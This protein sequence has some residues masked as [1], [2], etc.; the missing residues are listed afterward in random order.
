MPRFPTS[1]LLSFA[2]RDSFRHALPE[3]RVLVI[4]GTHN[5]LIPLDELS[6]DLN[7]LCYGN[8]PLI[9]TQETLPDMIKYDHS[10][11]KLTL[12]Y[13]DSVDEG[14]TEVRETGT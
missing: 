10:T 2:G 13:R 5:H 7:I 6:E 12:N 3:G 14:G 1:V 4:E 8:Q 9:A 11:R